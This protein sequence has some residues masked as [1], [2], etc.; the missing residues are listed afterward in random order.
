MFRINTETKITNSSDVSLV[1]LEVTLK[2]KQSKLLNS[3]IMKQLVI[4]TLVIVLSA[5]ASFAQKGITKVVTKERSAMSSPKYKNKKPTDKDAKS[6]FIVTASQKD[7]AAPAR[8]N[9]R[10]AENLDYTTKKSVTSNGPS[11]LKGPAFKN[12]RPERRASIN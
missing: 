8:K 2:C 1:V 12:D 6:T 4:F 11:D 3:T 10:P 5:T 7:N 9:S